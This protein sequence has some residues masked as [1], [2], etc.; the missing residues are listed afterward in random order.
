[1]ACLAHYFAEMEARN[2][3]AIPFPATHPIDPTADEVVS[4]V[5]TRFCREATIKLF[6][7]VPIAPDLETNASGIA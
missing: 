7:W 5:D 1:V 4:G 3:R 6:E 2:Q